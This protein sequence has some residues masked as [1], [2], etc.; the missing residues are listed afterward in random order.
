MKRT[1]VSLEGIQ[2]NKKDGSKVNVWFHP[3]VLQIVSLSS[4]PRRFV[5][6]NKGN[7]A[8]VKAEAKSEVKPVKVEKKMENK[9][10]KNNKTKLGEKNASN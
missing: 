10:Q 6:A 2:R 7:K 5:K 3:S 4:D 1:V 9:T 8:E